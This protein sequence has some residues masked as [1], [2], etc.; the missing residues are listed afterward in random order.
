M[1]VLLVEDN[2]DVRET[3]VAMLTR[4]QFDVTA[5]ESSEQAIEA[6]QSLPIDLVLTDYNLPGTNGI[7]V[8]SKA[9]ELIPNVA[10]IVASGIGP[11]GEWDHVDDWLLKPLRLEELK[12]ALQE[13]LAKRAP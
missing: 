4:L 7:E 8:L 1:R 3:M 12:R 10:T 6:L 5:T 9:R 11:P 13:A 2:Q